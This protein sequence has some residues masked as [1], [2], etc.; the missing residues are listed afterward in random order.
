MV[1]LSLSQFFLVL[2][3]KRAVSLQPISL[4]FPLLSPP[5]QH[6]ANLQLTIILALS[7]NDADF[8]NE[9]KERLA[10]MASEH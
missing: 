6:L 2:V 7:G 4:L 5:P 8:P 3:H 10:A 1:H 9:K